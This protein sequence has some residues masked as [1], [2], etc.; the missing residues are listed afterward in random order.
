VLE[1]VI[2]LET[3]PFVEWHYAELAN[4][5][6]LALFLVNCATMALPSRILPLAMFTLHTLP[7]DMFPHITPKVTQGGPHEA[8]VRCEL[9]VKVALSLCLI[10]FVRPGSHL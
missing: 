6:T 10:V 5:P 1:C 9:M 2:Y 8:F 3:F 7:E 4:V